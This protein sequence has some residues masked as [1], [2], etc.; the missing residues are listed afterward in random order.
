[1]LARS[2]ETKSFPELLDG[3][4]VEAINWELVEPHWKTA[5][6][7]SRALSVYLHID[8]G[9]RGYAQRLVERGKQADE[10]LFV[11]LRAAAALRKIG[12]KKRAQ[13]L[14][15]WIISQSSRNC[16]VIP[17]YYTRNKANFSGA[18]PVIGMGAGAYILALDLTQ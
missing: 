16:G 3:A 15:D 7:I 2:L 17:E 12:E 8:R 4:V 11:T 18:Y 6:S 9:K 5:Q 13:I 14:M 1:L 10:N